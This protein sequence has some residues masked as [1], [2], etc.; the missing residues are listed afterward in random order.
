MLRTIPSLELLRHE[1]RRRVCTRCHL[2]PPHSESLGPEVVR[3]CEVEC[4]VFLHVPAL[5]KTA[6]LTDPMLGSRA[7]ALRQ[8]TDQI[9]DATPGGAAARDCPLRRYRED[10]IRAVLEMVGET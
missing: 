3:P 10:V 4:P 5:R 7:Q 2:R 6:A 1:L 8:R 9:C